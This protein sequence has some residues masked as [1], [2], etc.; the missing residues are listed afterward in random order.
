MSGFGVRLGGA[1]LALVL[2]LGLAAAGCGGDSRTGQGQGVVREVQAQEGRVV[3]QHGDIPG[4]MKAMTMGFEVVDPAQLEGL[5]PGDPVD[6]RVEYADGRYRVT[7][8]TP[9][10]P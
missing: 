9:R 4:V 10:S 1:A 5:A 6:F 8:I 3:L 7:E 2:T